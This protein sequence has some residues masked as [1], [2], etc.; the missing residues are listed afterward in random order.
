MS[1][2]QKFLTQS[3]SP[4]IKNQN[5]FALPALLLFVAG[6]LIIPLGFWFVSK[7]GNVQGIKTDTPAQGVAV[8]IVSQG[9]SWD[10]YEYL[11]ETREECVESLTSGKRWES[12]HGGV[13]AGSNV[14]IRYNDVLK[15][16][17]YMR[18]AVKQSKGGYLGIR[19]GAEVARVEGTQVFLVPIESLTNN[20]AKTLEFSDQ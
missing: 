15:D 10:L 19:Q 5:G 2:S 18:V 14:F 13:T 11:C 3:Y 4:N 7:Q 6:F 9:D 8:Q 16:Y 1:L 20:T 12:V 17:K